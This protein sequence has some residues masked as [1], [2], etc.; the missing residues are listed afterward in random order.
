M[1][2]QLINDVISLQ[3]VRPA[4]DSFE[5]VWDRMK[6][7]WMRWTLNENSFQNE[8]RVQHSNESATE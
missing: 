5:A 7:C 6:A 2:S 1:T 3:D 4:M 8:T